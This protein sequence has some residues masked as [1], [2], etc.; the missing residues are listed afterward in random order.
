MITEISTRELVTIS[1]CEACGAR[2]NCEVPNG[3]G[4]LSL[5][6]PCAHAHADHELPLLQVAVF[7]CNCAAADIYP[8]P[9][10]VDN[11]WIVGVSV[12]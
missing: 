5:C 9:R 2:P 11:W 4:T 8:V 10:P 1:C 6:W 3:D 12:V 7:K